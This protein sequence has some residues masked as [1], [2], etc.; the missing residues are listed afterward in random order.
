VSVSRSCRLARLGLVSLALLGT[1]GCSDGDGGDETPT[2]RDAST[3]RETSPDTRSDATPDGA[4]D[5][6]DGGVAT[7]SQ[8]IGPSGGTIGVGAVSVTF[9]A[10]ALEQS[11]E[12][13]V[14]KTD[15][16]PPSEYESTSPLYRF[17]PAGQTFET[18][19]VVELQTSGADDSI[20]YWSTPNGE[21]YEP[22]PSA[23][24]G[25]VVR[26]RVA[27][28]ST[29]FAGRRPTC[30]G[31]GD[32]PGPLE[33]RDGTCGGA[34]CD[35]GTRDLGE[36]DVDCGGEA[37]GACGD[38]RNCALDRDC[39]SG[40]CEDGQCRGTTDTDASPD[41]GTTDA[42]DVSMTDD[43]SPS[44][45]GSSMDASPDAGGNSSTLAWLD[46]LG[47]SKSDRAFGVARGGSNRV[48][49]AGLTK[50][51]LAGGGSQDNRG[52]FP[53]LAQYGTSGTRRWVEVLNAS[54]EGVRTVDAVAYGVAADAQGAYVVGTMT[55]TL[56]GVES[57]DGR[58][59]FV[60]GYTAS[61]T[62][63]W[64]RL[65][66]NDSERGGSQFGRD[67]AVGGSNRL[68]VT[69]T[70]DEDLGG[71]S[72]NG[73]QDVFI[74]ALDRSGSRVWTRLL[75][76]SDV[77]SVQGIATSGSGDIYVA[78][79]TKGNLGGQKQ[80]AFPEPYVAKYDASGHRQWVRILE[81]SEIGDAVDVDVGPSGTVYVVG[82]AESELTGK[83]IGGWDAFLAAYDP[84]GT[85]QW[86]RM[87]GTSMKDFGRGVAVGS[88]NRIYLLR[89]TDR[90]IGAGKRGKEEVFVDLFDASGAE[91]SWNH[92]LGSREDE[93]PKDMVVDDS[94]TV[95]VTGETDGN[96]GGQTNNGRLDAF[97]GAIE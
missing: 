94:G 78:G 63:Q 7:A 17:E 33:C 89:Q 4:T 24:D 70:T 3:E 87:A 8:A 5:A 49:M 27:H 52:R 36:T 66:N 23:A 25:N 76:S 47:S 96:P 39:Q 57:D 88:S 56:N 54:Q 58:S 9:P 64:T 13:T 61:G 72:F 46:L 45:D 84:S 83:T 28:F 29:G 62:E 26:A 80:T 44:E 12:I 43:T 81:A 2:P 91:Q 10:G 65:I 60:A 75:G 95:F 37:C 32:C 16:P 51:R 41:G 69:G 40:T 93:N 79:Q 67:V 71:R 31:D 86:V 73:G 20:L 59:G 15:R 11:T 35:N 34:D 1:I 21:S 38:G 82:S 19:V 14:T 77:Q 85:R 50:G 6:V 48:Y 90:G 97:L 30:T 22:R 42:G 53:F 74:L 92:R 68:Y 18:P 55:G